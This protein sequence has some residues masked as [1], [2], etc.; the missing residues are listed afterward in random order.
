M[1]K[2][3]VY[4]DDR[5]VEECDTYDAAWLVIHKASHGASVDWQMT[6]EGWRIV[7]PA[8]EAPRT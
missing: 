8:T 2:F 3:R 5:L 7:S 6:Y 4:H 1:D